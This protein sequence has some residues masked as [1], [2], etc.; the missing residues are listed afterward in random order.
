MRLSGATGRGNGQRNKDHVY[1]PPPP[2]TL[3][4]HD[5]AW[6]CE[7]FLLLNR[8]PARLGAQASS[9]ASRPRRDVGNRRRA[10]IKHTDYGETESLANEQTGTPALPALRLLFANAK[11]RPINLDATSF[12]Q[13]VTEILIL[14]GTCRKL[15]T[16]S[17]MADERFEFLLA[18]SCFEIRNG[19]HCYVGPQGL[20]DVEL[21]R[22]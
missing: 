8:I 18:S 13:G 15:G 7:G 4:C 12:G 2:V 3:Y 10:Y 5:E 9:P 6:K 16:G 17:R 11:S 21:R 20:Y 19:R 14:P 22:T 1:P